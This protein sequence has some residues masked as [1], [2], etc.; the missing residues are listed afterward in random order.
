MFYDQGLRFSCNRCSDCCRLSPGVVYLSASDL[1]SLC[2]Q[3]SLSEGEFVSMY[4]RFLTYYDGSEVLALK[5][6]KNYDCILWKEGEGCTAYAS[7]PIQCSTYPFWSWII[8][9]EESWTACAS[10]C[11]GINAKDGR[12][13][14]KDEIEKN[15]NAYDSIEPVKRSQIKERIEHFKN[16]C[17]KRKQSAENK[18][19]EKNVNQRHNVC[20][21]QKGK[22]VES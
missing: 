21:T 5:E 18:N 1:S 22:G 20:I 10:D 16:E 14:K 3:F 8:E 6:R 4:C 17:Q 12:I 19:L 13:W 7:R 11:P 9:S 15:R 2:H